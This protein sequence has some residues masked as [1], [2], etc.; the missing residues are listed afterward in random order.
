MNQKDRLIEL[1]DDAFI[2]CDDNFGMP[3]SSQVADHLLDNA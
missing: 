3:N 2:H 1:L